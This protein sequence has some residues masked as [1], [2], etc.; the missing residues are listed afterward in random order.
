MGEDYDR[1]ARLLKA[2]C[3]RAGATEQDLKDVFVANAVRVY[4]LDEGLLD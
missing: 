1:T 3:D 2:A 4:S